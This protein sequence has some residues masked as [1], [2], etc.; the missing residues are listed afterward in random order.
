M[1]EPRPVAERLMRR[2]YPGSPLGLF[3]GGYAQGSL[4]LAVALRH[5]WRAFL[6]GLRP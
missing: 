2:R 6:R 5:V 3:R 4:E 1:R